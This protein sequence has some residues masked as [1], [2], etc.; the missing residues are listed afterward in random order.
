MRTIKFKGKT[1][2]DNQW[3]Y[4]FYFKIDEN[5]YIL[6]NV[7]GGS[8][9]QEIIPET[10]G[11]FTEIYDSNGK[12]I[13]EGDICQITTAI[14]R[15]FQKDGEKRILGYVEFGENWVNDIDI[16]VFNTFYIKSRSGYKGSIHYH[17]PNNLIIIGNIHDNPELLEQ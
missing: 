1:K 16:N 8:Q 11:Q 10:L 12:E 2:S 17:L 9:K 14:K 5:H 13:Y 6:E 3:V 7:L 4:G 15:G